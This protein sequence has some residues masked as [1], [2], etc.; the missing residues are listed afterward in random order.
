M[1]DLILV[2]LGSALLG[3][4][5]WAYILVKVVTGLDIRQVGDGNVGA[6]NAGRVAGAPVGLIVLALDGSKGSLACAL[7]QRH[8]TDWLF[9]YVAAIAVLVGH[10]FT[11]WLDFHGGKGL[12]AISGFSLMLWPVSTLAG[13]LVLLILRPRIPPFDRRFAAAVVTT[14]LASWL[15]EHNDLCGAGLLVLLLCLAGLKKLL[16]RPHE[17]TLQ[18]AATSGIGPRANH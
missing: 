13:A 8:G 2:V 11:P 1:R 6:R 7:A 3:S 15:V 14:L 5:P 16:D 10:A 4:I 18:G 12:A 9:L 17:R